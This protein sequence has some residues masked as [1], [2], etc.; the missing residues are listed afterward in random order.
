MGPCISDQCAKATCSRPTKFGR[1]GLA[2]AGTE[3]K[4]FALMKQYLLS[5]YVYIRF[6]TTTLR[7]TLSANAGWSGLLSNRDAT[8]KDSC[9]FLKRGPCSLRSRTSVASRIPRRCETPV[10]QR[11]LSL[12]GKEQTECMYGGC[13]AR[14]DGRRGRLEKRWRS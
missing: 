10:R 1:D 9:G 14:C 13:S 2:Y 8:H 12:P 4:R 3:A 11:G 5:R 6:G 7:K